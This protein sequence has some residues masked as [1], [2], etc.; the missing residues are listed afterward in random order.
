[1]SQIRLM[2]PIQMNEVLHKKYSL[3]FF[4]KYEK[5]AYWASNISSFQFIDKCTVY[6]AIYDFLQKQT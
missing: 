1:M 6:N 2:S 3:E 4:N 5:Y